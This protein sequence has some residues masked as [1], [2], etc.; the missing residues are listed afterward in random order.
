MYDNVLCHITF[1][2]PE[3]LETFQK[4]EFLSQL[5]V[6]NANNDCIKSEIAELW[7]ECPDPPGSS[8]IAALQDIPPIPN[9]TQR[10]QSL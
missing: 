2:T 10:F 5:L 9:L 4:V 7:A 1:Y 3:A 8:N 6:T